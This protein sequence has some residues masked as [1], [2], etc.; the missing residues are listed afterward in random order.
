MNLKELASELENQINTHMD[1]LA[2]VGKEAKKTQQ[3]LDQQYQ[4]M[5]KIL[6]E[7]EPVESIVRSQ[8]P[9]LC[10]LFDELQGK[11]ITKE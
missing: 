11:S 3:K 6:K 2:K 10:P 8:N 4:V 5:A 9:N 1:K 7:L